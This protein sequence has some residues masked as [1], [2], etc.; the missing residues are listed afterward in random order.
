[1]ILS[2]IDIGK[3]DKKGEKS[4]EKEVIKVFVI[5]GPETSG[6]V[7]YEKEVDGRKVY[8]G[9]AWDILQAVAALPDF[10]KYNQY[11]NQ[12]SFLS[13]DLVG[14]MY[15][16][17]LQNKSIVDKKM[18]AKKTLFKGKVGIFEIKNNKIN[19]IL[20]FYKAEDGEF[21]KVF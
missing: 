1:M 13:Y 11:P 8:S 16:L 14:L 4:G 20:N 9:M 18:F 5:T 19:H 21:K 12:L 6:I 7:T 2:D 17:I 15:Y 10:E 3:K